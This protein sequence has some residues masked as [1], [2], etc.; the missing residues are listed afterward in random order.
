MLLLVMRINHWLGL[1]SDGDGLLLGRFKILLRFLVR[2]TDEILDVVDNSYV[3][4][5]A[6]ASSDLLSEFE[7]FFRDLEQIAAGARVREGLK[8][9]VPLHIFDLH[10]VV[11]HRFSTSP[12]QS[13][14]RRLCEVESKTRE[15]HP[16]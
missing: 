4:G 1:S 9:L 14:L 16:K 7:L 8:L 15:E 10:V 2:V 6:R 11:R 3:E 13:L 5:T 12:D